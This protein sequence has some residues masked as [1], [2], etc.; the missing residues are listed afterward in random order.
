MVY[1]QA[2][3]VGQQAPS[4]GAGSYLPRLTM[5]PTNHMK[6]VI[7]VDYENVHTKFNDLVLKKDVELK[8]FLSKAL[9][10][11]KGAIHPDLNLQTIDTQASGK[12]AL[13]FHIVYHL[14]L[15]IAKNP[16]C[17]YVILSKDTGFDTISLA[18]GKQ[19]VAFVRTGDIT[20]YAVSGA[21]NGA[22][23]QVPGVNQSWI[24]WLATRLTTLTTKPKTI[25][26]LVNY[27]ITA[28]QADRKKEVIEDAD[29]LRANLGT[30]LAD[31]HS[32][33]Y[34]TWGLHR[35]EFNHKAAKQQEIL[36]Q[37]TTVTEKPAS[38]LSMWVS[39]LKKKVESLTN[40][41]KNVQALANFLGPQLA[42]E[43]KKGLMPK[44]SNLEQSFLSFLNNLVNTQKLI[45]G[46][47]K[48]VVAA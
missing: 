13:D 27:L 38:T 11:I 25:K 4:Q 31:L 17:Q 30:F 19:G 32:K 18:M 7:F 45:W 6:T 44:I 37:S 26:G 14:G 40:M 21:D 12:N 48:I 34:L 1:Y 29:T 16:N 9:P 46:G 2:L 42:A 35:V 8:V 28:L 20:P 3:M 39:W 33:G 15:E 36:T 43:V 23:P 5:Y 47:K 41:P 22:D 24:N 10:K